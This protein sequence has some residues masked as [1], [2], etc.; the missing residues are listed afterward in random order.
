MR[1]PSEALP[2]PLVH[3]GSAGVAPAAEARR[4]AQGVL[5]ERF[6]G[7]ADAGGEGEDDAGANAGAAFQAV[8]GPAPPPAGSAAGVASVAGVRGAGPRA[9]AAPTGSPAG[10]GVVAERFVQERLLR[11]RAAPDRRDVP[12]DLT[13]DLTASFAVR[14]GPTWP[15]SARPERAGPTQPE[16][17][18]DGQVPTRR[19]PVRLSGRLQGSVPHRAGRKSARPRCVPP[20]WHIPHVPSANLGSIL[21]A[22]GM[23]LA[24][25][26]ASPARL[27][28]HLPPATAAGPAGEALSARRGAAWAGV[29][30]AG[31]GQG[32]GA[33][34]GSV[35]A[36][37]AA[38]EARRRRPLCRP[39]QTPHFR[40]S[41][42]CS[43]CSRDGLSHSSSCR[44][45]SSSGRW[46]AWSRSVGCQRGRPGLRRAWTR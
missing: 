14:H 29:A 1:L 10:G 28:A 13:T 22:S 15:V 11:L 43:R 44:R 20:P 27:A 37:P 23:R 3:A 6:N 8:V 9:P 33:A 12:S 39:L 41:R 24:P 35:A 7:G 40:R 36:G 4:R 5:P 30:G 32:A 26:R 25:H 21:A 16:P 17:D 38:R 42:R 45:R 2:A 18:W 46:A 34:G 31:G 19:A